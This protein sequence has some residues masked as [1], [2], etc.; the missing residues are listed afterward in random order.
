MF[1]LSAARLVRPP[2]SAAARRRV[3][4]A[5]TCLH[6]RTLSFEL[7]GGQLDLSA[8]SLGGKKPE[9]REKQ[10]EHG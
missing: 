5:M 7:P 9:S 6:R 2:L 1:A 3:L 10:H 8:L 4:A